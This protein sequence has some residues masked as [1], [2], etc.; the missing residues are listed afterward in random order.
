LLLN[1]E[2]YIYIA[3]NRYPLYKRNHTAYIK[4]RNLFSKIQDNN[5]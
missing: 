2:I 4:I 1:K 3:L 5:K